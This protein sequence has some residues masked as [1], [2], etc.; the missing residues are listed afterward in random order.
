MEKKLSK[1]EWQEHVKRAGG[2]AEGIKGYCREH[3]LGNSSFHYWKKKLGMKS[4][5]PMPPPRFT[6]VEIVPATRAGARQLPNA[7]WLAEFLHAYGRGGA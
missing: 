1:M 5:P 3:D 6:P 7:A 2:H 4:P